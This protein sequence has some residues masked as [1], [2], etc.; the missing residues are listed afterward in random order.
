M[1]LKAKYLLFIILIHLILIILSL[2]LIEKNVL[3]FLIAEV[4]IIITLIISFV[5]Y[6]QLI[7]PINTISSG[8][9]SIEEKDF[10]DTLFDKLERVVLRSLASSTI[11][12]FQQYYELQQKVSREEENRKER[13]KSNRLHKLFCFCAKM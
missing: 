1:S 12:D 11:H 6:K 9:E 5:L 3:Y 10:S 7:M 4:F 2:T 8:V 13:R